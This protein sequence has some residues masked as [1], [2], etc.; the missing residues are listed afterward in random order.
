MNSVV[1]IF[2]LLPLTKENSENPVLIMDTEEA[3]NSVI[4]LNTFSQ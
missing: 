3:I 4:F 2:L 1:A